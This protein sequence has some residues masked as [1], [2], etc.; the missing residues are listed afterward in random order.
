[1]TGDIFRVPYGMGVGV[2]IYS[3]T[4]SFDMKLHGLR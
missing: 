3:N 4:V 1:M 2:P